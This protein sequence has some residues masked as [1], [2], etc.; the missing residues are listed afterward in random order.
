MLIPRLE[1]GMAEDTQQILAQ[2]EAGQEA[3]RDAVA[4]QGETL[5]LI[6]ERLGLILERL[7]PDAG[8]GPTLTDLLTEL[9]GRVGENWAMLRRIDVRTERMAS[10]VAAEVIR[11]ITT[12]SG[13]NGVGAAGHGAGGST[14]P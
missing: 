9:I 7:T 2:M 3:I 14:R 1:D 5:R 6:L 8:D 10:G 12:A 13:V 11:A 4:A